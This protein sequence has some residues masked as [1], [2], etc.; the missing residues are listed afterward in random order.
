MPVPAD[1]DGDGKTDL[2]VYRPANGTWYILTSS[3][4][5]TAD[6]AIQWG[7]GGDTPVPA[8]YDGDRRADP[9]VYRPAIGTWFI[10]Q[11]S[12]AYT[13]SVEY[14]WGLNGDI[15]IANVIV[16]NGTPWRQRISRSPRS[17]TCRG[18]GDFDGDGRGRHH[19]LPAVHRHVA[20]AQVR[21]Q[22][23]DVQHLRL[24]GIE[25]DVPVPGDYDGDGKT[26]VAVYRPRPA[27][28]TASS[29]AELHA[30][31]GA[32]RGAPAATSR[33]PA[34]TT[35]TAGPISPSTARRPGS[36]SFCWSHTQLHHLVAISVADSTETSPIPGDYD[37]DGLTDLAVYRPSTGTWFMLHLEL[38]LHVVACQYGWGLNGDI[39]VAGDYDG[40]GQSDLAVYRPSNGGW[41]IRTSST[42]YSTSLTLFWGLSGDVPVAADYDGDGA[43]D[44]AV[45][46][47]ATSEWFILKSSTG[48]ASYVAYLWGLSGDT[49]ILERR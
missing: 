12:T 24:V 32:A 39:P 4:G 16:A 37:G 42:G 17:R 40:D 36:G 18:C 49:P 35:A 33:C 34:T 15:P 11:S 10:L 14:S 46:R 26:D 7:L 29:R 22:L 3:S 6:L 2:A 30:E 45:Y 13:T 44:L 20:L 9:A 41:Y 28:G 8:D 5:Y 21:Q 27:C 25:P 43:T 1:Y 23:L 19:G 48:Y 38:R 31:P 47:P